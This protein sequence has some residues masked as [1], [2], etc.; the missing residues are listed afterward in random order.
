MGMT[1]LL[2]RLSARAKTADL[3]N[4]ASGKLVVVNGHFVAHSLAI[5]NVA[6]AIVDRQDARPLAKAFVT[7]TSQLR[8]AGLQVFVVFDGASPPAKGRTASA[9]SFR[10]K[11]ALRRRQ[12]SLSKGEKARSANDCVSIN[13]DVVTVLLR[14]L[15]DDRFAVIVA[16]YEA[17]AQVILLEAELGAACVYANDADLLVMGVKNMVSEIQLR[18]GPG[19]LTGNLFSLD[20]IIVRPRKD[21]FRASPLLRHIHGRDAEGVAVPARKPG[22]LLQNETAVERLEM[23]AA[24]RGCDWCKFPAIGSTTAIKRVLLGGANNVD[25]QAAA[26][27]VLSSPRVSLALAK[28]S[29]QAAI[30]IFRYSIAFSIKAQSTIHLRREGVP[31]DATAHT[32][33]LRPETHYFC[34][35][36][37]STYSRF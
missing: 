31:S 6:T 30:T 12:Q 2:K 32:G 19:Y 27:S 10:C 34:L 8:E 11:E 21:E 28:Q 35:V 13:Q 5:W 9:R 24:L 4:L 17:D 33:E 29:I 20:D 16:P 23:V 7:R 18:R 22:A 37:N 36:A 1:D 26:V 25:R 3:R 15:Q 14:A